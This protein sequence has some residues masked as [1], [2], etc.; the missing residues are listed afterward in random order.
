MLLVPEIKPYKDTRPVR[1]MTE[2]EIQEKLYGRKVN[3]LSGV[4]PQLAQ[5]KTRIADLEGALREHEAR[6]RGLETRMEALEQEKREFAKKAARAERER[7][8]LDRRLEELAAQAPERE[9]RKQPAADLAQGAWKKL[10]SSLA[11]LKKPTATQ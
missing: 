2:Q 9:P 6:E 5:A 1:A 7:D 11:R 3:V 10:K 4:H 8:R